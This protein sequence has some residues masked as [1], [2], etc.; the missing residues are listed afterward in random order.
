M[1]RIVLIAEVLHH[2]Y[3]KKSCFCATMVF[4]LNRSIN[5]IY[6]FPTKLA[7]VIQTM[8]AWLL[9]NAR[10]LCPTNVCKLSPKY[11]SC[12]LIVLMVNLGVEVSF[13][14][15]WNCWL[16]SPVIFL[17]HTPTWNARYL[18]DWYNQT[19]IHCPHR[20]RHPALAV[21]LQGRWV[22]GPSRVWS[23]R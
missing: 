8:A 12:I 2:A 18:I 5:S 21:S 4:H 22:S 11:P 23:S 14:S 6:R 13:C 1:L 19:N 17:W 10:F 7:T 9:A 16:Y 20:D 3:A 15:D